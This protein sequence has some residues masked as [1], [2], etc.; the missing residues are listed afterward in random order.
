MPRF[1]N[2]ESPHNHQRDFVSEIIHGRIEETQ[3]H[4]WENRESGLTPFCGCGDTEKV[5]SEKYDY[6]LVKNEI[7]L[8]GQIYF[9]DKEDFHS[10][11]ADN[12]T[13]TKVTKLN[14][15]NKHD[16]I[17]LAEK[18]EHVESGMSEDQLWNIVESILENI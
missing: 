12:N 8:K 11:E 4:V 5:I 3:Y 18:V 6:E 10:V 9:V 14:Y 15:D 7:Y 1:E 17:I 16:A 2:D 13:I